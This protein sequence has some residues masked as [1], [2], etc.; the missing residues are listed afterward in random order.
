MVG[1]LLPMAFIGI[2]VYLLARR[3]GSANDALA[4]DS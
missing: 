2:A 4:D 3:P 1:V